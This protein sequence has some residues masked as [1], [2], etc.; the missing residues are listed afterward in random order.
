LYKR[1]ETVEGGE[2]V[3]LDVSGVEQRGV[4]G[5]VGGARGGV[6]GGGGVGREGL[7][8]ED[9]E[10]RRE[11]FVHA[12][13]VLD[14]RL[15]ARVDE[16]NAAQ[17]RLDGGGAKVGVLGIGAQ[18]VLLD[19]ALK[20]GV[21]KVLVP[22]RRV[23]VAQ[24]IERRVFGGVRI[25]EIL[26][27]QTRIVLACRTLPRQ[28]RTHRRRRRFRRS[29]VAVAV[30]VAQCR[31]PRRRCVV[32][33][34]SPLPQH[35]AQARARQFA[36]RRFVGKQRREAIVHRAQCQPL[37][38][39]FRCAVL[40]CEQ[41]RCRRLVQ[42]PSLAPPSTLIFAG[43]FFFFFFFFTES[44]SSVSV[45]CGEKDKRQNDRRSLYEP[46]AVNV[47]YRHFRRR[48]PVVCWFLLI[49]SCSVPEQLASPTFSFRAL[50]FIICFFFPR[51]TR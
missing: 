3:G 12:L 48:R 19:F 27:L 18:H 26:L 28:P 9:E 20:L 32:R 6:D 22:R 5:H 42:S 39:V 50:L 41:R 49:C 44:R 40:L 16:Q 4:R 13:L 35:G 1:H 2:G 33:Q 21:L 31:F 29:T 30:A 14:V 15:L 38:D 7:V 47:E 8:R 17:L 46:S 11:E 45:F 51:H 36:A 23:G 10:N 37:F 43:F 25:D 24:R 34:Q